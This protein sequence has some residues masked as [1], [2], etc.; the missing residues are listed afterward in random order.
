MNCHRAGGVGQLSV[1]FYRDQQQA[2]IKPHG[3]P[4]LE[5][6]QCME[7]QRGKTGEGEQGDQCHLGHRLQDQ[8]EV[9][10][11]WD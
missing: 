2:V 7:M 8:G 1:N 6:A 4:G 11:K 10:K 5:S 3:N 9:Q